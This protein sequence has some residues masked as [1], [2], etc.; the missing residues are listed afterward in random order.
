MNVTFLQSWKFIVF[1]FVF[2]LFITFEVIPRCFYFRHILEAGW[3]LKGQRVERWGITYVRPSGYRVSHQGQTR[4]RGQLGQNGEK[5]HE[6]YKVN[7]FWAKQ[8]RGT[9][10][11]FEQWGRFLPFPH[12]GNPRL[13]PLIKQLEVIFWREVLCK[14]SHRFLRL[15]SFCQ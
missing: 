2:K 4:G 15:Q 11:F 9:S 3:L 13:M 1:C 6:N 7:I 8:W 12:Q 5:L 10:Q 14:V